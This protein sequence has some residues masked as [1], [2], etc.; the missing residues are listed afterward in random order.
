MNS[1]LLW[2][3]SLFSRLLLQLHAS[4]YCWLKPCK[5]LPVTSRRDADIAW[6]GLQNAPEDMD[7]MYAAF[8]EMGSISPRFAARLVHVGALTALARVA[9]RL[10]QC[11]LAA[12]H[13]AGASDSAAPTEEDCQDFLADFERSERSVPRVSPR[14]LISPLL[15]LPSVHSEQ[16]RM[17]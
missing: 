9:E 7:A 3:T 15:G 6:E 13:S 12:G 1:F 5:C 16:T 14:G 2:T 8:A 17:T 4:L 10:E 11:G